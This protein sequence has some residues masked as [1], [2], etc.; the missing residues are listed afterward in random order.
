MRDPYKKK[1]APFFNMKIFTNY[2]TFNFQFEQTIEV[3]LVDIEIIRNEHP[4]V[5]LPMFQT[6]VC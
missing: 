1:N 4:S 2:P 3:D 6:D 5:T